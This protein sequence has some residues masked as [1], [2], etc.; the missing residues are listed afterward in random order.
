MSK[1]LNFDPKHHPF[2]SGG[3]KKLLIDG[4]WT[5]SSSG[6]TIDAINPS[7]GEHL[8]YFAA[9][10]AE[11][12]ERAV[13]SSRAA[14]EGAWSRFKPFQR[15]ELLLK[16][17][18]LI[19]LHFEELC[20]LDT[21]D[22]GAPISVTR[23]RRQRVIG[24]LRFYAGMST[25]L[26]GDT[27]ENSMPG[28]FTSF[29]LKD[30]VGVVGAIIPWNG[31]MVAAVWK[32][33]PALAAGCTVILK[34]SE[35][36]SLTCLRLGELLMEAGLPD[37]VLNIVTGYGHEAGAALS[38]HSGVDKIAFT[39]STG[40]GRRLI[41]ASAGNF[42][43]LSLELG[44]KSPNIIFAD[45][46]LDAAVPGAAMAVF[47]NTGQVCSAGTRLFVEAPI[48]DEFCARVADFGK[49]LKVGN[50][51]LSETQIGPVVSAR[52]LATVEHYLDSAPKEGA[53]AISG[54]AR[55]T[56]AD[57]DNGFFVPPTVYKDVVDN[58]AIAREEIFGPVI[59]ALSFN[60]ID[61]V[62]H[63]A[64]DT[65]YGLGSGVW[66]TNL[67]TAHLMAK[68]LRAGSVWINCY[69]ASDPAVP[70]GGFKS[71]G[72]G[73]ESGIEHLYQYLESKSVWI[74]LD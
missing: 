52:Q 34:P 37:G 36:A 28:N 32:I 25:A 10:N 27:I 6:K 7:T 49:K 46:D 68:K 67:G 65:E 57:Y 38:T 74:N 31:P 26:H 48:Y 29:T 71:S 12:V 73:R 5:A 55:L 3:H 66:T 53:I 56:G 41:E 17:G 16:W 70:F 61:E 21:L 58:M 45:A 19:D 15:Q 69:Q 13:I 40:T 18:D 59:S 33:A 22:M 50:A 9:G 63:R 54:G 42:K 30:P 62:I 64:N 24:M 43:R 4:Q 2:L 14:F 1:T 11:D 47:S 51:A 20:W 60:D 8:A 35:E 72:I 44:G 39:G 23:A